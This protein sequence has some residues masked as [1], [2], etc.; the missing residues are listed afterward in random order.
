M[1]LAAV[2]E[3]SPLLGTT[4]VCS[5]RTFGSDEV[6]A[7]DPAKAEAFLSV[8]AP[9]VDQG[10]LAFVFACFFLD[11]SLLTVVNTVFANVLSVPTWAISVLIGSKPFF[12][13]LCS[14][15]GAKIV[16]RNSSVKATFRILRLTLMVELVTTLSY[17][18]GISSPLEGWDLYWVLFAAR[19]VSGCASTVMGTAGMSLLLS[20]HASDAHEAVTGAAL[21]GQ[22]LGAAGGNFIGGVLGYFYEWLPFVALAAA[23]MILSLS[24]VLYFEKRTKAYVSID[25]GGRLEK[26]QEVATSG[27][28]G[29]AA[30]A[31]ATK[32]DVLDSVE[33]DAREGRGEEKALVSGL[34]VYRSE[35]L[36]AVIL[37]GPFAASQALTMLTV[38]GVFYIKYTLGESQYMQAM[39]LL[40]F[41]IAISFGCA[42]VHRLTNSWN[43][44]GKKRSSNPIRL[45]RLLFCGGIVSHLFLIFIMKS[46]DIA[47]FCVLAFCFG[48]SLSL[49]IS[50]CPALIYQI[51]KA[52][53]LA[54]PSCM[55]AMD[56]GITSG[57]LAAT[58][59]TSVLL[60]FFSYFTIAVVSATIL[61]TSSCVM[62][63]LFWISPL[64]PEPDREVSVRPGLVE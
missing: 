31:D 34:G 57:A 43:A 16:Q 58:V 53:K 49:V 27:T 17:A 25:K 8:P 37:Q 45:P 38:V 40:S 29:A 41:E 35:H 13:I 9:H 5:P 19:A 51:A 3:R 2:G 39:G 42:V 60:A 55:A 33:S 32:R 47:T 14:T 1:D 11:F 63:S 44:D 62:F 20:T 56:N 7:T 30:G 48:L 24:E 23:N 18:I 59:M 46:P 6:A 26:R 28:A 64:S 15:Y 50:P 22:F 52:R 36:V 12:N 4:P 21:S 10:L 61:A 54:V